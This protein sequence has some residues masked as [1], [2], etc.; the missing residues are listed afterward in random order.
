[1]SLPL[2]F[3]SLVWI[4][5]DS[6]IFLTDSELLATSFLTNFIPRARQKWANDLEETGEVLESP[7]FRKCLQMHLRKF[8]TPRSLRIFRLNSIGFVS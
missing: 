1:M 7:F 2:V 8:L 4:E 3:S 6:T 5:A